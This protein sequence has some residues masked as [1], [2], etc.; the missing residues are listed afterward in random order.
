ME[1]KELHPRNLHKN[2]YDFNELV[3]C[4]PELE[5]HVYFN[6]FGNQ[7]VDF[8]DPQAVKALNKALLKQSYGLEWEVPEPFLCPPI[9]GRAD[10]IHY[11]ADL[12]GESLGVIPR[13]AD[14]KV[15]DIGVGA[16][17]IYPFIG[18]KE[19]GWSFVGTDINPDAVKH[20]K[21][22]VEVNHLQ[23]SIEIRLQKSPSQIFKGVLH[24]D[25]TRYAVSICNPPFHASAQEAEE[26]SQRKLKN[27]NIPY[28]ALNFGGQCNELWCPGGEVGLIKRMIK[29]SVG[30]NCGW[31]T[32]LVSKSNSLPAIYHA[33]EQFNPKKVKTIDMGQGQKKSRMIAWSF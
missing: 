12:I 30:I 1:K 29:E 22:L 19:Y 3:K 5:T 33:L 7:S 6:Q 26:G 25:T 11:V 27:L 28:K 21:K 32:S 10:Y 20:A 9:P 18:N 2:G 16:N 13:G 31:F 4:S 24:N 15:L 17:C 23:D 14:V 8:S